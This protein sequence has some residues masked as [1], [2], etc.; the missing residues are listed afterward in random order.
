MGFTLINVYIERSLSITY[1][2]ER[3]V[4]PVLCLTLRRYVVSFSH[5]SGYAVMAGFS[6]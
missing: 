2:S 4:N 6:E 3:I 5:L 1:E